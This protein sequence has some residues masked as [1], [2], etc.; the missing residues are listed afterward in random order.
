MLNVIFLLAISAARSHAF[1]PAPVVESLRATARELTGIE[2]PQITV[3][4]AQT[5]GLPPIDAPEENE[6]FPHFF[7]RITRGG[8]FPG[9]RLDAPSAIQA[10]FLPRIRQ[11]NWVGY[12]NKEQKA[13]TDAGVDLWFDWYKEESPVRLLFP[14]AAVAVVFR[15]VLAKALRRE[16]SSMTVDQFYKTPWETL[17]YAEKQAFLN[18]YCL[19]APVF[20]GRTL[21]S[22][23]SELYG[24]DSS[25]VS[26]KTTFRLL[27]G[28]DFEREVRRLGMGGTIYFRAI[29][30]PDP[31]DKTRYVVLLNEELMVKMSEFD[32]PLLRMLEYAG[33]FIHEINHVHQDLAAIARGLD[34]SIRSA[35]ALLTLEGMTEH[36]ALSALNA[37]GR[38][39]GAKN[40]LPLFAAEHAMLTVLREGNAQ[41]GQLFPYTVGLP[42]AAALHDAAPGRRAEIFEVMLR[43]MAS[44][45]PLPDALRALFP[46]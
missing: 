16:G 19:E 9:I 36:Y 27:N 8:R 38:A 30:A 18:A 11:A 32:R 42:F 33:I 13:L 4:A 31:D 37:A 40:P 5:R 6:T 1:G 44:V 45:V 14:D 23:V 43:V 22:Y 15:D 41:S 25:A 7:E 26:A 3:A 29:T 34:L 28:P 35:E 17:G 46:N 20:G 12:R 2:A 24:L 39:T 10:A 21:L